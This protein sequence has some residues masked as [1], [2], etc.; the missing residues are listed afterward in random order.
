MVVI[1]PIAPGRLPT[2]VADDMDDDTDK[3][4]WWVFVL[5]WIEADALEATER[6]EG[7]L[8]E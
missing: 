6:V 5:W 8:I 2:N 1:P 7:L 4:L 3:V